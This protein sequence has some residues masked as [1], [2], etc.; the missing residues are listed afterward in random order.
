MDGVVK[1]GALVM[2]SGGDK[3]AVS[4]QVF[5]GAGRDE[6]RNH[7]KIPSSGSWEGGH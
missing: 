5:V 2:E 4:V 7:W 6:S 1:A 3:A